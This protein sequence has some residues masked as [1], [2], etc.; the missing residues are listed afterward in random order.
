V[1]VTDAS[2]NPAGVS[3][4]SGTDTV[5]LR[6]VKRMSDLAPGTFF[7]EGNGSRALVACVN[8][9]KGRSTLLA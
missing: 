3:W 5:P 7:P 6:P 8:L 1:R 9:A 2:N 4:Q